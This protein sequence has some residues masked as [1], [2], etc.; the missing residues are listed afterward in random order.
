MRNPI[1]NECGAYSTEWQ[2]HFIRFIHDYEQ[3]VLQEGSNAQWDPVRRTMSVIR[4]L[5]ERVNL[6]TLVP[7]AELAST[8]YCLA[9]PGQEYLV[10]V[11]DGG[12]VT[13]D[14]SATPGPLAV[15]W[16]HAADGTN[17]PADEAAGG[18]QRSFK[19]PFSDDAVLYPG[20]GHGK[21][22]AR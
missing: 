9:D 13:V 10:F 19:A 18:G 17:R 12:E 8:R 20:K 16:I 22:P 3:S 6:A 1:A 2:E 14:L 11:P 4:R 21:D 7:H 5:A 15:E